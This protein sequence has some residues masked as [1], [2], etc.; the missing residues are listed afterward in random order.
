M[1]FTTLPACE[2]VY[3]CQSHP[4]GGIRGHLTLLLRQSLPPP[5]PL[6]PSAPKC[7]SHVAPYGIQGPPPQA[8]R[9]MGL[10]K[11]CQLHLSRVGCHVFSHLILFRTEWTRGGQ[12]RQVPGIPEILAKACAL[13]LNQKEGWPLHRE[14]PWQQTWPLFPQMCPLLCPHPA[15]RAV[16]FRDRVSAHEARRPAG[17]QLVGWSVL[18]WWDLELVN[19][20]RRLWTNCT[21]RPGAVSK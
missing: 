11:C 17:K 1:G 14:V 16:L 13:Q 18:V 10:M 8:V 12:N 5:A 20:S 3:T 19:G 9:R 7:N 2:T 15:A 4:P 6:V 21:L